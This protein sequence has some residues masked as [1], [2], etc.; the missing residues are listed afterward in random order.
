MD[1]IKAKNRL[2]ELKLLI[3]EHDR[4]YYLFD[5]P[6]ITDFEYDQLFRELRQIEQT[7]PDL[8]SEDSPTVKVGGGFCSNTFAPVKH[9]VPM[10]SIGNAFDE[11]EVKAFFD[12][13][14]EKTEFV[15]EP[16]YDGLACSIIYE[17]GKLVKAAT[18]GDGE[19]GEDITENVKTIRNLHTD[20]Y[21]SSTVKVP[22]YLE[23]RGEIF[24]S[25]IGFQ[26]LNEIL[27][28][29]N[30]KPMK[31][32]RNAAA[33]SIRQQDPAVC[34]QRPLVFAAYSV[35]TCVGV[36]L[37]DSHFA[38]Y[39]W[40]S[41]LGIIGGIHS[42]KVSTYEEAMT[43]IYLLQKQR[44]D[45]SFDID[46]AVVKV[47][48]VELQDKLG[49]R[50]REPKWAIAYKYPPEEMDT[51]LIGV[52][53]Q[54]G[55]TGVI[56][57]VGKLTPV[58]V[59]GVT[60]SNAT[61]HNFDHIAK[62]NIKIGDKVVVRRAGDVVPEIAWVKAASPE[63]Q[64]IE[65][66]E[67]CPECHSPVV[68]SKLAD[69]SDGASVMCTGGFYCKAQMKQKLIHFVS[70]KA[71][72]IEGVGPELIDELVEKGFVES[73]A[74]FYKLSKEELGQLNSFQEKSINNILTAIQKSKTPKLSR[75]LFALG[76]PSVGEGT[77]KRLARTYESMDDLAKATVNELTQ[78]RD[79]GDSTA[80]DIFDWFST[81]RNED[82]VL[83]LIN[84]GV[85]PQCEKVENNP[86]Q[87]LL[88][89]TWVITGTLTKDR[90]VVKELL[91]SMGAK[92][93]SSVSSK[94]D[95]L[96]A[97]ENAGSKLTRAK[98]LGIRII[99]ELDFNEMVKQHG[100]TLPDGGAAGSNS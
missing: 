94:T 23:V 51:Y 78:I 53:Y 87:E 26:K 72:D 50:A 47:D 91:E 18:R 10:L 95:V 30:Q 13:I 38:R 52:D 16:K 27:L 48:S 44:P 97:G 42:R 21:I 28:A 80:N 75:F 76:I 77:S 7:Y 61:L 32:P 63:G 25:K 73:P 74:D 65:V 58:L 5:Q 45:L 8:V 14:K 6:T 67:Q 55:R 89:Q 86:T 68:R 59:G 83:D 17:H 62:L 15:V 36:D 37:D 31:N 41:N 46:G 2:K 66:P 24:I 79:I 93:S 96:L 9:T 3:N 11:S 43:A 69:G 85:R 98:S 33:G 34:S 40:L 4:N 88:G 20:L 71:M 81:S 56:T 19:S 1:R 90:E 100:K 92:V 64:V 22:E 70:R 29:N 60:V 54:V 84:C 99:D 35:V 49:A 39:E 82:I 57:P 12:S